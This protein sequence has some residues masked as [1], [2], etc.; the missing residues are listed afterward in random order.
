MSSPAPWVASLCDKCGQPVPESNRVAKVELHCFGSA[1]AALT[2][3][4]RHLNPVKGKYPCEG[5]PSRIQRLRKTGHRDEVIDT[6]LMGRVARTTWDPTFRFRG[7]CGPR[8]RGPF[9]IKISKRKLRLRFIP[10]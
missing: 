10:R 2:R 3:N 8:K 1:A 9:F 4:D 6:T 5:S 7:S